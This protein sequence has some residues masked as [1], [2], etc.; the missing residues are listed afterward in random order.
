MMPELYYDDLA[1]E[2]H[3]LAAE[4]HLA[5]MEERA[6]RHPMVLR[7]ARHLAAWWRV[8][9][10][11]ALDQ[12]SGDAWALRLAELKCPCVDDAN[13]LVDN[14]AAGCSDPDEFIDR[15]AEL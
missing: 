5:R 7:A 14:I 3:A 8:S 6:R 15:L 1:A 11:W 12:I 10:Q 9:Q 13:R 4:A 2:W